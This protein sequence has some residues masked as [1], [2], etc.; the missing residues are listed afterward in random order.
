MIFLPSC[1]GIPACTQ[2]EASASTEL[3]GDLII[4]YGK[5]ALPAIFGCSRLCNSLAANLERNGAPVCRGKH[6]KEMWLSPCEPLKQRMA[7]CRRLLPQWHSAGTPTAIGSKSVGLS[8]RHRLDSWR[9]PL[10]LRCL[11]TKIAPHRL[12]ERASQAKEGPALPSTFTV[13]GFCCGPPRHVLLQ[14]HEN[15]GIRVTSGLQTVQF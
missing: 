14:V 8:F 11:W 2:H 13:F 3:R 1:G 7:S 5:P 4:Q 10:P 9:E 6:S 15:K 12:R